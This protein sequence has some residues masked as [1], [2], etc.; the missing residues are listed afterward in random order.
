MKCESF[1]LFPVHIGSNLHLGAPRGAPNAFQ[2]KELRQ[3]THIHGF[4][5]YWAM[6]ITYLKDLHFRKVTQSE[7]E[8]YHI[9]TVWQAGPFLLEES[10]KWGQA[11]LLSAIGEVKEGTQPWPFIPS[12]LPSGTMCM[13][14]HWGPRK[15][16]KWEPFQIC[17]DSHSTAMPVLKDN[18]VKSV[19]EKSQLESELSLEL[20]AGS[21]GKAE[22][23]MR[24]LFTGIHLNWMIACISPSLANF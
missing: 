23:P 13:P 9:G 2:A 19:F 17:S 16:L 1:W 12:I 6:S 11:V 4:S 24:R 18:S 10:K 5:K 7:G 3:R 14:V 20:E 21:Q 15:F 22:R 8:T